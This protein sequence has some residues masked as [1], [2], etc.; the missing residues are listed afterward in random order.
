MAKVKKG[1]ASL[2]LKQIASILWIYQDI[3]WV[4]NQQWK[5]SLDIFEDNERIRLL[6]KHEKL[7]YRLWVAGF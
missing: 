2:F 4:I 5:H 7:E 6:G 1:H 3:D